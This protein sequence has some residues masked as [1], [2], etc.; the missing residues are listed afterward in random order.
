MSNAKTKQKSVTFFGVNTYQATW[1]NAPEEVPPWDSS[2][3]FPSNKLPRSIAKFAP[4]N[5]GII[6]ELPEIDWRDDQQAISFLREQL[7]D[8]KWKPQ[9]PLL[10][11]KAYPRL[12]RRA[13]IKGVLHHPKQSDVLNDI[14]GI[15]GENFV[16]GDFE[17]KPKDKVLQNQILKLHEEYGPWATTDHEPDPK[18]LETWVLYSHWV[19]AHLEVI[20]VLRDLGFE[21]FCD[22]VRKKDEQWNEF[23]DIKPH[24]TVFRLGSWDNREHAVFSIERTLRDK[25]LSPWVVSFEEPWKTKATLC[26]NVALQLFRKFSTGLDTHMELVDGEVQAMH[27]ITLHKLV[28]YELSQLWLKFPKVKTCSECG[29]FFII[30]KT[31]EDDAEPTCSGTCRVSESRN[32]IKSNTNR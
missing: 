2:R 16:R 31:L 3:A 5:D 21:D 19:N 23:F 18:L 24:K 6:R 29:R 9:P 20:G 13:P 8:K 22:H 26:E 30:K 27:F 11:E 28:C 7:Q 15:A 1:A 32:S 10:E 14:A 4:D 17:L 12:V 25:Y